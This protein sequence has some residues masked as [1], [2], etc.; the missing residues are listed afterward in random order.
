M[1]HGNLF[2]AREQ[3]YQQATA[4]TAANSMG[5]AEER[6]LDWATSLEINGLGDRRRE[7]TERAMLA[8]LALQRALA[9]LRLIEEKASSTSEYR[10]LF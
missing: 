10:D 4:G 5:P 8:L 3:P 9:G 7:H 2:G 6:K 1:H